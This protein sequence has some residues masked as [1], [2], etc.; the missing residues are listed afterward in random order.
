[1]RNEDY[2]QIEKCETNSPQLAI[3]PWFLVPDN[4]IVSCVFLGLDVELYHN[5]LGMSLHAMMTSLCVCE[6]ELLGQVASQKL[7]EAQI[8][9]SSWK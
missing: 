5:H 6:G 7:T 1:M 8:L 9:D 2:E 3:L 4:I